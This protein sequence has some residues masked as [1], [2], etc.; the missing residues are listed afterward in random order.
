MFKRFFRKRNQQVL[1]KFKQEHIILHS[2]GPN[3]FGQ[4]SM[5]Y[6]QVRGN[7]VLVLT[8]DELYFE[9]YVPKKIFSFPIK[10]IKS[11]DTV[12]SFLGTTKFSPLSRISFINDRGQEDSAA[13]RLGDLDVWLTRLQQVIE[14]KD[15]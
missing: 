13:W 14:M 10:S 15:K 6:K 7:G 9:M 4:E 5:R 12:K 3:F 2:F 8:G 1:S 11:V